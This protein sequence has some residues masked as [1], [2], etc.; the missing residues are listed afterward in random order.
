MQTNSH[1]KKQY[2]TQCNAVA[3]YQPALGFPDC[4]KWSYCQKTCHVV[5]IAML[6]L[7]GVLQ[8]IVSLIDAIQ[9]VQA[10]WIELQ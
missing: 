4:H 6:A 3:D 1:A 7:L 8:V 10:R 2:A 9:N 5:I